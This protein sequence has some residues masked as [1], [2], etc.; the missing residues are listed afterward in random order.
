MKYVRQPVCAAA[1][2]EEEEESDTTTRDHRVE[3][4]FGGDCYITVALNSILFKQS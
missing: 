3:V 1:E 4:V 2:E